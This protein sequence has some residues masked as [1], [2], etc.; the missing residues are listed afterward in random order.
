MP[1]G[2]AK[3]IQHTG[4]Y[5]EGRALIWP[6]SLII[7][8]FFLWGFSYGLLDVLNAHFQKVLEISKLESTGLQIAYF[9]GGYL[10]FSPIAAEVMR[11]RSYKFTICMGLTLY[12][13]GAVLFWPVSHYTT[14]SNKRAAFGGFVVCTFVIACGLATLETA[15]NSYATVIGNPRTAARR[16]QFC[17]SFNGVASFIGPLI[18]S[19]AFF[20][21]ANENSLTNVQYVYLAVACA[22]TAVNILF[23][24]TRMPEVSEEVLEALSKSQESEG[25]ERA[26]LGF[27]K[28]YNLFAAV[29]AQF[30]YVGAQVTVATFFINYT[31]EA[32]GLTKSRASLLLSMSLLIFTVARFIGT[33]ILTWI[34]PDF[35][36]MVYASCCILLSVLACFI[37]GIAGVGCV[38]VIFFFMSVTYPILFVLGT[39]KLGRHTRRGSGL[40]VMGVSGGAVFPPI[41]G[42]IA[43]AASTR[44]SYLVPAAGFV[45][46][47]AYVTIHWLKNG[48]YILKP[49]EVV[50]AAAHD[51]EYAPNTTVVPS[52]IGGVVVQPLSKTR[53]I[54]EHRGVE[55]KEDI[56]EKLM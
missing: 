29:V 1:G 14:P 17:Q 31:N 4:S 6:L 39:E 15:A 38:M 44:I 48:R 45:V 49:K 40:M 13:L 22:G 19:H 9:G 12:A 37:K 46:V 30:A 5:L 35:L 11:R 28:Q 16:L 10:C 56:D 36:M 23:I 24:C 33:A 55:V 53:T 27:R 42:A 25:G 32:G 34:Q 20:N 43:D 3:P 8:L 18:A 41:Q 50:P 7:S 51:E 54:E 52:S 26:A 21:G 2:F 47:L